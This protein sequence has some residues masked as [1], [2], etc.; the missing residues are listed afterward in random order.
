MKNTLIT[1]IALSM[2]IFASTVVM[3]NDD[4]DIRQKGGA[5]VDGA[6]QDVTLDCKG[7]P[8]IIDGANNDVR[9][10]GVCSRLVI[11][12]ANNDVT[13]TLAPGAPVKVDGANNEIRWRSNSKQRPRVT[14]DGTNNNIVRVR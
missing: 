9:F 10:V 1:S 6:N 4:E 14:V 8:A 13:I 11:D 2:S 3:A 5:V 12:G 7:G